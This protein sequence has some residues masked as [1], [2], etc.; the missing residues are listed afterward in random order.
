MDDTPTLREYL[1]E[2]LKHEGLYGV[3]PEYRRQSLLTL[4]IATIWLAGLWLLAGFLLVSH[5]GWKGLLVAILGPPLLLASNLL[6]MA[7][8]FAVREFRSGRGLTAEDAGGI[9]GFFLIGFPI[10]MAVGLGLYLQSWSVTLSY[11]ALSGAFIAVLLILQA[12]A[13]RVHL[14]IQSVKTMFK[15]LGQSITLLP[16]FIA[17]LLVTVWL[18]VFSEGLWQAFAALSSKRFLGSAFVM[19]LPVL[20]YVSLSVGREAAE[21]FGESLDGDGIIRTAE[22]TS[23]IKERLERGLISEEEWKELQDEFEWRDKAKLVDALLPALQSRTKQWLALLFVV[24][25]LG[26]VI[27]F[28]VYFFGFFSVLLEPS[29][30]ADWVGTQMDV[31]TIPLGFWEISLPTTAVPTAKVSL[32]LAMFVAVMSSVYALTD[33]TVKRLFTE[34]LRQKSASWLSLSSLYHCITSPGYQVWEYVVRDADRSLANVSIVVPRGLSEEEVEEACEHMESR[35]HEWNV[36]IVTA[37]EQSHEQLYRRGMSGRRWELICNQSKEI[38]RFRAIHLILDELRYEDFLGQKCLEEG[39]TIPH[40]WFG[41]TLVEQAVSRAIWQTDP[42]HILV[43]HPYA[44]ETGD[45]L[46]VEIQLTKRLPTSEQ[47]RDRLRAFLNVAREEAPGANTIMLSMNY[48]DTVD[49]LASL[50]WTG[51]P[52]LVQYRDG[53][54]GTTRMESPDDWA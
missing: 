14:L 54:L 6:I 45:V 34:W 39:R 8:C 13:Y 26:V 10:V 22:D 33:E 41:E 43:L 31:L 12:R 17:L 30:V 3:M 49:Q 42:D 5:R 38:R 51:D 46:S 25:S 1:E 35:L 32:M 11:A 15:V 48:R 20:L 24:T 47:Y 2:Y 44:V 27:S 7:L 9:G 50:W 21:I 52:P 28:F 18:S 23:F 40:E 53:A 36:V 4:P 19:V 37:F 29:L 16:A